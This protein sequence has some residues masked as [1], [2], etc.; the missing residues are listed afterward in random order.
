[1]KK[2]LFI[3]EKFVWATSIADAIKREKVT[4]PDN[5]YIDPKFRE[6]HTNYE[7]S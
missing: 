4:T 5:V 1:M 7:N 2:K 3:V 6:A